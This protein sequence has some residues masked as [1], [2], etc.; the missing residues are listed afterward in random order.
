MQAYRC[1]R[2]LKPREQTGVANAGD[3]RA[4]SE[5]HEDDHEDDPLMPTEIVDS[6]KV[7]LPIL[8]WLGSR[9]EQPAQ[10]EHNRDAV[11]WRHREL[12]RTGPIGPQTTC[13]GHGLMPRD[14]Q[15]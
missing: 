1:M 9:H 14:T 8:I 15:A 2:S 13:C 7:E 5:E 12:V 10:R 6:G 11:Q 3:R 4:D